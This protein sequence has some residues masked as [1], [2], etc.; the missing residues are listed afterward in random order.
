M[1]SLRC[2]VVDKI[3]TCFKANLV[4][5]LC[6]HIHTKYVTPG[7]LTAIVIDWWKNTD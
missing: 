4:A 5:L 6:L 7:V 2:K 3:S 1:Q